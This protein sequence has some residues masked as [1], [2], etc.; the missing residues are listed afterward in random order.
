MGDIADE[1]IEWMTSRGPRLPRYEPPPTCRVC[2][3][4]KVF[5]SDGRLHNSTDRTLHECWLTKD[6]NTEG[7]DDAI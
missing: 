6:M 1:H 2:G 4:K 5:W 3:T 7:F